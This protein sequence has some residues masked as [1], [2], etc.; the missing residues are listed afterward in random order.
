MSLQDL[1]VNAQSMVQAVYNRINERVL[2]KSSGVKPDVLSVIALIRDN[3]EKIN[4][5]FKNISSRMQG[6]ST[7][8]VISFGKYMYLVHQSKRFVIVRTKP[9]YT[10]ITYD[11]TDRKITIRNK[12]LQFN[13][14]GNTID[15]SYQAVKVNLSIDDLEEYSKY[16]NELKYIAKRLSIA[17]EKT[18]EYLAG[19][20]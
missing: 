2:K 12:R 6:K 5:L 15:A 11:D 14:V 19:A 18:I 7:G 20:K 3:V 17:L 16:V 13:I 10:I 4:E 8:S 9:R 1:I